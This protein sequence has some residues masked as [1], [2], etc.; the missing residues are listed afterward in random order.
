MSC[1]G[2]GDSI[3]SLSWIAQGWRANRYGS[4][5][6]WLLKNP[7]ADDELLLAASSS[8]MPSQYTH[9]HKGKWQLWG[10]QPRF[11]ICRSKSQMAEEEVRFS[12]N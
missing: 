8:F 3:S 1:A 2:Q 5:L 11:R 10:P 9:S 4:L 6:L 12:F 7:K